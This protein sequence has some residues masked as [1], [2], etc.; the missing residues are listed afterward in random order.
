MAE[1]FLP[2]CYCPY[3]CFRNFMAFSYVP[4]FNVNV[5]FE[6]HLKVATFYI[7]GGNKDSQFLFS[8]VK[9]YF[10]VYYF[11]AKK[12]KKPATGNYSKELK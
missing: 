9:V 11:S 6:H 2:H 10:S 5:F 7:H 3:D 4:I 1:K 8:L 12:S